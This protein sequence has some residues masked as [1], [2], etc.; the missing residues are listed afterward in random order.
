MILRW[1]MLVWLALLTAPGLAATCSRPIRV[2]AL[3]VGSS[4]MI[5]EERAVGGVYPEMLQRVS[6]QTGCRFEFVHM[7]IN[8]AFLMLKNGEVDLIP[9]TIQTPERNEFGEFIATSQNRLSLVY[10]KARKPRWNTLSQLREADVLI[11]VVRGQHFGAAY[12]QWLADARVRSHLEEVTSTDQIAQKLKAGRADAVLIPLAGFADSIHRFGMADEIAHHLIVDVPPLIIGS[13]LSRVS[14][15]H[16]DRTLLKKEIATI[17]RNG[18]YY[19]LVKKY[20]PAWSLP[21]IEPLNIHKP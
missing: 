20:Y 10:L 12:A 15:S 5:Y 2:A 17:V 13:Y 8:R 6:A 14:L 3:P 1:V 9:V 11:N 18:D 19:R 4:F 21:S 16:A 7:P